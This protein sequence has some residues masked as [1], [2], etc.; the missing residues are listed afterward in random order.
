MPAPLNDT[1]LVF[2]RIFRFIRFISLGVIGVA[3]I[4]LAF[5]VAQIHGTLSDVHPWLGHA[6]VV[7]LL[8]LLVWLVG[9][10]I[11]RFLRMPVALK[12]PV[13]PD[14]DEEIRVSHLAARAK[15]LTGYVRTLRK[16]PLMEESR[17]KVDAAAQACEALATRLAA[18][19]EGVA[20]DALVEMRTFEKETL[21][22]LLE[23][24]DAEADKVIRREALGV[25]L[26]TAISPNGTLDAFIVLWRNANMV[27]HVANLYYGRPGARGSLLILR[28]VSAATLLATYLEGLSDMAGGFIGNMLGGIAGTLA[29]PIID[30]SVNALATLRIGYTA[31]G[32]CRSFKAWTAGSRAEAIKAAFAAAKAQGKGVLGDLVQGAGGSISALP[33]KVADAAKGGIGSLW[34]KVT[35][36][37]EEAAPE[38]A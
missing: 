28:D 15:F 11:A 2:K 34:R 22:P 12:P 29:G 25:G 6:F 20:P 30:G 38:G 24:I 26:A 19:P 10:P 27:S 7:V 32:R 5:Q 1:V 13:M 33:G 8:A 4:V 36:Q 23:P 17:E 3:A 21:D 35:G 9:I 18:R 16:N 31:R 37:D 14:K